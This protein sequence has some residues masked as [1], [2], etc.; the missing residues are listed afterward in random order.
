[1]KSLLPLSVWILMVSIGM[2]LNVSQL[3]ANWRSLTPLEW[4]K[5]LFA[6]FIAPPALVVLLARLLPLTPAEMGGLFMVAVAPGAPLLTRGIAKKGFDMQLAA[7]YQVW[8]A[9]LTPVMIPII[10]AAVGKLYDRDIWISPLTLIDQIATK[11]FVPLLVGMALMYFAPAVSRKLQVGFNFLGNAILTIALVFLLVKMGGA[12]RQVSP[13]VLV[14]AAILAFGCMAAVFL[15]TMKSRYA[16]LTL[17]ISNANRHVGL[18]LLL[19]GQYL[20]SRNALPAVA[21]YAI[22]APILMALCARVAR[23]SSGRAAGGSL[24]TAA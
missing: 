10:V 1:V 22:A 13:W 12:L 3:I 4:L 15:V 24:P 8:G 23:S 21:C 2:S 18:A 20:H 19:T 9:L 16:T 17:S 6:T 14:A 7:S 5:L 11:Q